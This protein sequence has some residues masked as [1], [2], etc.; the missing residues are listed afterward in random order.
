[1]SKKDNAKAKAKAAN[2]T[3]TIAQEATVKEKAW[4]NANAKEKAWGKVKAKE[5]ARAA[6]AAVVEECNPTHLP[7]TSKDRLRTGVGLFF[8]L[9]NKRTKLWF[10]VI[11][12]GIA[13][14]VP[15]L[16]HDA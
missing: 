9:P 7:P 14:K 12:T 5:E 16:A 15:A 3:G 11:S 10:P 1:M 2:V 8:S 13:E 6:A 4:A